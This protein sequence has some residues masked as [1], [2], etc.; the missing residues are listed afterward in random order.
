MNGLESAAISILGSDGI[1]AKSGYI[2]RSRVNKLWSYLENLGR[3]SEWCRRN[4]KIVRSS[5]G[6]SPGRQYGSSFA[7]LGASDNQM[8]WAVRTSESELLKGICSEVL[9]QIPRFE[10]GYENVESF[11]IPI[12]LI[13]KMAEEIQ[14][15]E[16]LTLF[17]K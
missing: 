2:N 11:P 12:A 8:I 15:D 10:R 16:L 7:Q 5:G 6:T 14:C 13:K 3:S 17:D 9:L 1:H 4:I